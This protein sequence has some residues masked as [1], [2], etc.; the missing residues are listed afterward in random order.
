[1]PWKPTYT[2]QEASAAVAE[3]SSWKQALLSLGYAYHGR[4]IATL[5][6]WCARWDISVEHL[7][8][9]R[10]ISGL[11]KR[12]SEA[13]ARAAIA[14]SKSYAEALRRMGYCQTGANHENLKRRAQDWEISTEHFD[15]YAAA[16]VPRTKIP[17]E[18]ILVEGSAYSRTNLKRRLYQAGL[19]KPRCELCSQGELWRGR[20]IGL[21]LDHENGVRDDNRLENLRILCPNCA[22]GLDTHCGRKNGRNGQPRKC[23]H[24]GASFRAKYG[25]H[26]FCSPECSHRA[27]ALDGNGL[28]GIPRPETRKVTRPPRDQLLREVEQHGFLAVGRKYGVSDNAIRK[29]VRQYEREAE[30]RERKGGEGLSEAA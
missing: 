21:I 14:E 11:D 27:R 15:P 9:R 17:L 2:R 1:M 5:R 26:R 20:A 23:K 30:R 6:K 24:C 4:N 10:E 18:E 19:K 8:D 28:R 25:K 13:E 22:A 3:A 7:P 29:W 12:Y 16:R